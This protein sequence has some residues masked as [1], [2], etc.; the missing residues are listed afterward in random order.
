MTYTQYD[1]RAACASF[2]LRTDWEEACAVD[3][4]YECL[5]APDSL[6]GA[7]HAAPWDGGASGAGMVYFER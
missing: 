4:T 1:E 5:D 6:S 3:F 2:K 7:T